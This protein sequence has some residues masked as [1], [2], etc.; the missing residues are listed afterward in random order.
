MTDFT[1]H[2]KEIHLETKGEK[3]HLVKVKCHDFFLHLE[4]VKERAV[5]GEG[6]LFCVGVTLYTKIRERKRERERE[7]G[8]RKRGRQTGRK[9]GGR[10]KKMARSKGR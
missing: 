5:N 8:K 7:V 9:E 10:G 3:T 6:E 2:R 1:N 4:P